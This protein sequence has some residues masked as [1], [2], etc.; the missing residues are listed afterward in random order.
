MVTGT[1]RPSGAEPGAS[2]TLPVGSSTGRCSWPRAGWSRP[3]AGKR[4]A[5]GVWANPEPATAPGW[6]PMDLLLPISK[7][8]FALY[9]KLGRLKQIETARQASEQASVIPSL[10][11]RGGTRRPGAAGIR[12]RKGEASAQ[13]A[14]RACHLGSPP[15]LTLDPT[16]SGRAGQGASP[17]GPQEKVRG[18]GPPRTRLLVC[19]RVDHLDK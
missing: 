14:R 4:R 11:A 17:P 2:S 9:R 10:G 18:Q 19:T 5:T 12:S 1:P 15:P 7:V 13:R 3:L 8:V 16:P 6:L